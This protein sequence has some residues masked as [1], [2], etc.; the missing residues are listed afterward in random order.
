MYRGTQWE[1]NQ[2]PFRA[3]P[4]ERY[5]FETR[6]IGEVEDWGNGP[7]YTFPVHMAGKEWVDIED[8]I[9]VFQMAWSLYGALQPEPLD[10]DVMERTIRQARKVSARG[11]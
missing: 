11:Y 3:I 1:V 6:R 7:I 10:P 2:K 5:D 4:P 9:E 8:F